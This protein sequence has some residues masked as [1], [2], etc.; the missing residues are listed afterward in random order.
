MNVTSRR[1]M[2]DG[3]A[4]VLIVSR[5][6]PPMVGG[7]ERLVF[8]AYLQLEDRY[9]CDVI[10]PNLGEAYL[11][12]ASRHLG[13]PTRLPPFLVC[14]FGKGVY[15]QLRSRYRILFAGSGV[16]APL[17][18]LLARLFGSRSV[19]Y[20]HGLDVIA[21]NW[22]YQ[23]AFVPLFRRADRVVVNSRNTARLAKEKGVPPERIR[24]INPGVELPRGLPDSTG[25]IERHGLSGRRLLLSVGRIIPRKGLAEFVTHALPAVVS[26]VPGCR[27]VVIG[28]EAGQALKKSG[29]GVDAVRLA[30]EQAGMREHVVL[31]GYTDDG[32]LAAAY[33]AADLLVFPLRPTAG[34]VEGFGMVAVEA[35]A[36]GLPTVAFDV[37][38]VADAIDHGVSGVLV[39]PLDY[40][41]LAQ[42]IVEMLKAPRDEIARQNCVDHAARFSWPAFGTALRRVFDEVLD[43]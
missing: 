38:G 2:R 12:P 18:V 7:M 5:N 31:L 3:P 21:E 20:L 28:G 30:A 40:R 24:I 41:N 27:L 17:V 32:E 14:A 8:N 29:G 25:F 13:C 22:L 37:G 16:T 34:D 4:R 6:F 19:I 39:E 26:R 1:S 9:R 35:A 15:A 43:A 11:G 23:H 10:S 33:A 36:H 42:K